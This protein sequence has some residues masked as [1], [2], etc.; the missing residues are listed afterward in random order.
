MGKEGAGA[1]RH[2]WDQS[3]VRGGV[4]S[5]SFSGKKEKSCV[6]SRGRRLEV[7]LEEVLELEQVELPPGQ[8]EMETA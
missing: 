7:E 6:W 8:A 4:V 3:R 5:I 2:C 1:K